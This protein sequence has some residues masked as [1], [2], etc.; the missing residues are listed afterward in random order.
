MLLC[1]SDIDSLDESI[2]NHTAILVLCMISLL[3][4]DVMQVTRNYNSDMLIGR[5]VRRVCVM[6]ISIKHTGR[7]EWDDDN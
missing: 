5:R 6:L 4:G 3:T 7:P 2:S 1:R